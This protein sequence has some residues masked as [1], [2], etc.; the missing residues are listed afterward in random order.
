MDT[1][2]LAANPE[3]VIQ[4]QSDAFE[5]GISILGKLSNGQIFLCKAPG[6]QFRL[7]L[8]TAKNLQAHILQV[9][10]ARTFIS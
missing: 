4:E 2:P 8:H 3:I 7:V 5:Q 1:N 9:Y 6:A 10:R